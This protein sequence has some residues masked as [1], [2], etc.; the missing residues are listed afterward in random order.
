MSTLFVLP[1]LLLAGLLGSL[2]LVRLYRRYY[3]T[4]YLFFNRYP[5][6]MGTLL[7][8]LPVLGPIVAPE[9]LA[10]LFVMMPREIF[11]TAFVACFASWSIAYTAALITVS[12]PARCSLPWRRRHLRMVRLLVNGPKDGILLRGK[13]RVV[14]GLMPLFILTALVLRVE[15]EDYVWG[16]IAATTGY[17]LALA[18]YLRVL[19]FARRFTPERLSVASGGKPR[20]LFISRMPLG[21]LHKYGDLPLSIQFLHTRA[22]R[23]LLLTMLLYFAIGFVGSPSAPELWGAIPWV[24]GWFSPLAYLVVLLAMLTWMLSFLSFQFDRGRIPAVAILV[25]CI[26]ILQGLFPYKHIYEV[27]D[28]PAEIPRPP[29]APEII[30]SRWAERASSTSVMVAAGGGGITASYWTALVLRGLDQEFEGQQFAESIDVLSAVSG[31]GI[32]TMLYVDGFTAS[33]P[34][35]AAALDAVVQQSV[36]SSL[37]AVSWGMAYPDLWRPV[38]GVAFPRV[39]RGWAQ[40]HVWSKRLSQYGTPSRP[41]RLSD[42]TTGVVDRWRPIHIANVTLQ[43]TGQRLLLAPVPMQRTTGANGPS[44]AA[45]RVGDLEW[46]PMRVDLFDFIPDGDI[47]VATAARLSATFPYV[48]PQSAP[49]EDAGIDPTRAYHASDGGYY[50]NSGVVTILDLLL[51]TLDAGPPAVVPERIAIVEIRAGPAANQIAASSTPANRGG[52]VNST[53]GPIEALN[54]S[55]ISTQISRTSMEL[56]LARDHWQ[57]TSGVEVQ[58]FVFHL[59]GKSP[60]SWHLSEG[61]KRR[62]REHWPATE[63][64]PEGQLDSELIAAQAEQRR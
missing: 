52:F 28:W 53:L 30:E 23:V 7:V 18:G 58:R 34:P 51:E 45:R 55:R 1:A 2:L 32:A 43:E 15:S 60:L 14:A 37:A 29:A 50:D 21:L 11:G 40:D 63:L 12:I 48:S 47:R 27:Y 3:I 17:V 41:A 56:E 64:S 31:G 42:W 33:G 54:A 16:A 36:A 26:L 59:S 8:L 57:R 10:N 5:L 46:I 4:E 39:D 44:K 6:L 61:E 62:I 9:V 22:A 20:R 19:K 25:T 35:D 49:E 38:F 13:C 24:A